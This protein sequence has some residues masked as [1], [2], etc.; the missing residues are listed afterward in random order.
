MPKEKTSPLPSPLESVQGQFEKWRKSRQRIRE[1]IPKELWFAATKL[2]YRYSVNRVSRTLHLNYNDLKK[3]IPGHQQVSRKK[4]LSS[5]HFIELDWPGSF[6]S[7]ECLIELENASGSK[8]RM[9]FRG[10]PDLDLLE[11]G[12]AFWRMDK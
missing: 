3:R 5:P 4:S 11:L 12:K 7:S 2:C 8:M 10:L 9:S 1:P 6:S